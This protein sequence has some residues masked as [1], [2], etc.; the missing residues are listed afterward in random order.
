[1]QSLALTLVKIKMKMCR[2]HFAQLVKNGTYYRRRN[3]HTEK[4]NLQG[5]GGPLEVNFQS[6]LEVWGLNILQ[7]VVSVLVLQFRVGQ[8]EQRQQQS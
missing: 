5:R 4:K 6:F 3:P 1:M 2:L 7:G 8:F